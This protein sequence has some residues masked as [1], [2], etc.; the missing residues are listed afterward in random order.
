MIN[1]GRHEEPSTDSKDQFFWIVMSDKTHLILCKFFV[2]WLGHL[3]NTSGKAG[4]QIPQPP[5]EMIHHP[6]GDNAVCMYTYTVY[7]AVCNKSL[8]ATY[9]Y[10]T[11]IP[12]NKLLA[13]NIVNNK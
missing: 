8:T 11:Q 12:S 4:A 1:S 5:W 13:N 10:K 6:G 9:Q 3:V 7:T 2:S